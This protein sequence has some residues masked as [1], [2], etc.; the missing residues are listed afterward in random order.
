LSDF[1]SFEVAGWT[2]E[3]KALRYDALAGRVTRAVVEPLLDAL[4]VQA[5]ERFLDVATGPGHLA[6]AAATRGARAVGVD[7]SLDMLAL[8]R[9]RYADVAFVE[10]DAEQ[11]PFANDAFDAAAAAFVLHHV[12]QPCRVTAELLRVAPRAAVATWA[13]SEEQPLFASFGA[14]FDDAGATAADLRRGPSREE[15]GREDV[16]A[17]LLPGARVF[18]VGFE[19]EFAD[20]RSLFDGFLEGSVNTA[21]RLAAQPPDVQASVRDGFARRLDPYRRGKTIVLPVS[22]KVAV[23]GR[24]SRS[25]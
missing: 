10:G 20:A 22:V 16:L 11:L 3:G 7:V 9:E 5:G 14:A 25:P 6:A 1:K 19:H 12:P 17:A 24:L 18:T 2:T 4:D 23:A 13:P 21:A 8:A 15:L